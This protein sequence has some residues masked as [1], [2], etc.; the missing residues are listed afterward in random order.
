MQAPVKAELVIIVFDLLEI[1]YA[2]NMPVLIWH[3]DSTV[4]S[5]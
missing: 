4:L 1:S 2:Y 5:F 3:I